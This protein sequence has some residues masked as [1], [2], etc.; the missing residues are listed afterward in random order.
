MQI[1]ASGLHTGGNS[2]RRAS[3]LMD[4]SMSLSRRGHGPQVWLGGRGF[5]ALHAYLQQGGQCVAWLGGTENAYIWDRQHQVHLRKTFCVECAV[6]VR[7]QR[8]VYN[9][10]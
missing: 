6:S 3:F 4:E 9:V 2:R 8:S 5:R 10:I 1:G 7:G